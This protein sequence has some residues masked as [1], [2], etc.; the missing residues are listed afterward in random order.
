MTSIDIDNLHE[1]DP[2]PFYRA[3]L[4][5]CCD[6][7]DEIDKHPMEHRPGLVWN[8]A[9]RSVR[10]WFRYRSPGQRPRDGLL[11][12]YAGECDW[13]EEAH[14]FD[15]LPT[16]ALYIDAPFNPE[17]IIPKLAAVPMNV[18]GEVGLMVPTVIGD[19]YPWRAGEREALVVSM[20][21]FNHTL[22][23]AP[24]RGERG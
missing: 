10:H 5:N 8:A 23:R 11:A 7:S 24:S 4:S 14:G 9:L 13:F 18:S 15:P 12:L 20:S 6:A 19:H 22:G 17:K 21:L 1:I 16:V 3:V 2:K